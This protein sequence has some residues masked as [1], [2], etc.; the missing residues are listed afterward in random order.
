MISNDN[1][2]T[3]KPIP[4]FLPFLNFTYIHH[5]NEDHIAFIIVVLFQ[6]IWLA[7]LEEYMKEV[8]LQLPRS[9]LL[10]MEQSL[11]STQPKKTQG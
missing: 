4:V 6:M 8:L 9:S 1:K 2:F 5:C 3:L 7:G 11:V 10:S